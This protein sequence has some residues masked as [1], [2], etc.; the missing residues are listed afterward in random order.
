M[1]CRLVFA[2]LSQHVLS[3]HT[4]HVPF[5]KLRRHIRCIRIEA[6]EHGRRKGLHLL[7]RKGGN[8]L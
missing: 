7:Y 6:T 4:P 5:I 8:S 2:D 1:V 3:R